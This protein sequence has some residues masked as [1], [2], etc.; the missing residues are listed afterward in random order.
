MFDD[1]IIKVINFIK[2]EQ[3]IMNV[4]LILSIASAHSA[5]YF[6]AFDINALLLIDSTSIFSFTMTATI[7]YVFISLSVLIVL[8]AGKILFSYMLF[9]TYSTPKASEAYAL[10]LVFNFFENK[11]LKYISIILV[12]SYFYIGLTNTI[13]FILIVIFITIMIMIAYLGELVLHEYQK[14]LLL[15]LEGETKKNTDLK[16]QKI[17]IK[18]L[19]PNKTEFISFLTNKIAIILVICSILLGVYRASYIKTH[20]FVKINGNKYSLYTTTSAGIGL[21]DN[22]STNV[23]FVSWDN[24]NQLDFIAIKYKFFPFFK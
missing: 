22:N 12:F 10:I 17:N 23:L 11:F 4:I 9:S 20:N 18:S 3:F 15:L 6:L 13:H 7:L 24:I 21:Y 5:S 2:N 14:G 1:Y 16:K 19:S 8:N